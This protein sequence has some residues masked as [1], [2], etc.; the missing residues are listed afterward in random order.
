M[1]KLLICTLVCMYVTSATVTALA[2]P[3]T[4][5][6]AVV[7]CDPERMYTI[8]GSW[9]EGSCEDFGSYPRRLGLAT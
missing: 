7:A 2:P 8:L 4:E 3:R 1:T 5:M 9:C 6:Y